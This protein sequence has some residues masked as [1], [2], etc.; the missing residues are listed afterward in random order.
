MKLTTIEKKRL[1]KEVESYL[2]KKYQ[3][4]PKNVQTVLDVVLTNWF[5]ELE[6]DGS[7]FSSDLIADNIAEISSTYSSSK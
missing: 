5:E 2:E 1:T 3:L 6:T 7:H 4:Q